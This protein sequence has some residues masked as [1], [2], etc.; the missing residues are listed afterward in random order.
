MVSCARATRGLGRPSL[1]TRSGRPSSPPSREEV[2]EQCSSDACSEGQSG[3]SLLKKN[4]RAW[5]DY[6]CSWSLG[7]RM[8]GLTGTILKK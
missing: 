5:R 2:E 4:E 6:L 8:C 3:Y 1:D 7:A